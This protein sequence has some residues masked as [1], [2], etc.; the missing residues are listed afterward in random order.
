MNLKKETTNPNE[1]KIKDELVLQGMTLA[2][3]DK[4]EYNTM[5]AFQ[6]SNCNT[7]GYYIVKWTGNAYT[8]QGKYK[9]HA[10]NPPVIIPEGELVCPANFMTP[11]KKTSHWYHE[12][13]EAIPVMVKL[14]QVVMTLIELIQENN[15]TNMLP[16]LY[17]VYPDMNPCLLSVH[18]HQVILGNIEARENLNHDEYLE[19]NITTKDTYSR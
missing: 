18:N 9:C 15:T 16:L 10:F 14:K 11:M 12:P 1:M 5:G 6:T 7:H 13:K 2:A 8:L 3:A 19:K 4:I 17:L